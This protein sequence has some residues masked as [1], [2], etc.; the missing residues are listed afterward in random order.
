LICHAILSSA[1][2]AETI[3]AEPDDLAGPALGIGKINF[4][5]HTISTR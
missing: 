2:S 4:I 3:S 1:V 5:D